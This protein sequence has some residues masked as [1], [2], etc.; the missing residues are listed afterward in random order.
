[1]L[2]GHLGESKTHTHGH[3]SRPLPS[4]KFN[5]SLSFPLFPALC[6]LPSLSALCTRCTRLRAGSDVN[7]F[8][9][10][11]VCVC[12][13][14]CVCVLCKACA[15]VWVREPGSRSGRVVARARASRRR[16]GCASDPRARTGHFF[17][18]SFFFSHGIFRPQRRR[19]RCRRRRRR[20]R[21]R[22]AGRAR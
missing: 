21:R 17:F 14:V 16:V 22:Q 7:T 9:C 6:P 4:R 3:S 18:L 8:V 13:C 2:Q 10:M 11:R 12:V 1:M 15:R 5:R 20:R 19:A